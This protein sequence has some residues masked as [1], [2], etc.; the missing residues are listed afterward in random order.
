MKDPANTGISDGGYLAFQAGYAGSI[1]VTRSTYCARTT[2][3]SKTLT[4]TS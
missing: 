3:S 2:C 4:L 1:P